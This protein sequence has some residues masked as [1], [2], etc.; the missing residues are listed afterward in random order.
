MR[1]PVDLDDVVD[2]GRHG[3]GVPEPLVHDLAAE[4]AVCLGGSDVGGELPPGVDGE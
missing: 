2:A 1:G 3:V 4:P